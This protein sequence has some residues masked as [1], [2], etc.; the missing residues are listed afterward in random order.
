MEDWKVEEVKTAKD[1]Q[2][3]R[4]RERRGRRSEGCLST[5]WGEEPSRGFLP[6]HFRP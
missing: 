2:N 5:R 6:G 1:G 3:A 4:G